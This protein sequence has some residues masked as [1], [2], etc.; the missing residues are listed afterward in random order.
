MCQPLNQA[1]FDLIF[2]EFLTDQRREEQSALFYDIIKSAFE[3][4][5]RAAGGNIPISPPSL[6]NSPQS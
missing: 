1:Q 3:A 4:G 2:D 6:D 5:Y